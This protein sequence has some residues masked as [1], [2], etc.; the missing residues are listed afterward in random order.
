MLASVEAPGTAPMLQS[1]AV[2]KLPSPP[3]QLSMLTPA[4]PGL[5]IHRIKN[6]NIISQFIE[7]LKSETAQAAGDGVTSTNMMYNAT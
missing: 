5:F 6:V 7:D 1:A 3:S 4:L 2:W